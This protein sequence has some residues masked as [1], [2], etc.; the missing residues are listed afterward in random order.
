MK[1]VFTLIPALVFV[2][3]SVMQKNVCFSQ[4]KLLF[5]LNRMRLMLG[6]IRMDSFVCIAERCK[7]RVDCS[8]GKAVCS[9]YRYPYIRRKTTKLPPIKWEKLRRE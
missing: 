2:I 9:V 7:W 6:G 5:S 4:T 8:C 3:T 1:I